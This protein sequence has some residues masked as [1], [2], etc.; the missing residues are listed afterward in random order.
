MHNCINLFTYLESL[1]LS[2]F[3]KISLIVVKHVIQLAYP[4]Y[5][6]GILP[7]VLY[8]IYT[9]YLRIQKNM[10]EGASK[11]KPKIDFQDRFLLNADQK[12]CRMP[13]LG[14][15]CNTLKKKNDLH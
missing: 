5:N 3:L 6:R 2:L 13:P 7:W 11:K 1:K 8:L 9:R 14:A 15:F 4:C 10:S 12:Y